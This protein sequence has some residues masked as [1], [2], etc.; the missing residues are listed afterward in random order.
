MK[1]LEFKDWVDKYFNKDEDHNYWTSIYQACE[2]G[3]APSDL[4]RYREKDLQEEYNLY[5]ED[6]N[7]FER[8]DESTNELVEDF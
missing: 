3:F 4:S 6:K 8:Y 7:D 1:K 2:I 5:L